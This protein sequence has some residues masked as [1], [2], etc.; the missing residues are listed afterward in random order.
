MLP[1]RF[2]MGDELFG[3]LNGLS[4]MQRQRQKGF[5]YRQLIPPLIVPVIKP[6]AD[7]EERE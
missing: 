3:P 2:A 5:S 6:F 4:G 1:I 7:F